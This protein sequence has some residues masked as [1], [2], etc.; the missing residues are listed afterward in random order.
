MEYISVR[1][2]AGAKIVKDLTEKDVPVVVR[3]V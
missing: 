3:C 2:E 1:E